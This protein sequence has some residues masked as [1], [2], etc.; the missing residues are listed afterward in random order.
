M[1]TTT[2]K[3]NRLN[4]R[5]DKHARQMFNKAAAY[6]HVSVSEFILSHALASAEQVIQAHESITLHPADFQAFLVALDKPVEANSALSR[7]FDRHS[8]Q[9]ER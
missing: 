8:E 7:A 3:E 6:A 9:V 2:V 1:N 5:C 4:I